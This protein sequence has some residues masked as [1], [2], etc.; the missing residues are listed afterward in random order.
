MKLPVSW[1]PNFE[2]LQG[3]FGLYD[4]TV[5]YIGSVIFPA[6]EFFI[7]YGT[8]IELE[9]ML[10]SHTSPSNATRWVWPNSLC[11]KIKRSTCGNYINSLKKLC[12]YIFGLCYIWD[13]LKILEKIYDAFFLDQ[14]SK[15]NY[16]SFKNVVSLK[17]MNFK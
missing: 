17:K 4:P 11:S 13:W 2:K 8:K 9:P 3:I 14:Y 16:D 5:I 1:V 15:G 10:P 6:W 12:A 7:N